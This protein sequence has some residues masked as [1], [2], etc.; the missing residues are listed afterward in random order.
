M[1]ATSS[2]PGDNRESDRA[3]SSHP[4][5][6]WV[7]SLGYPATLRGIWYPR[8]LGWPFLS[9]VPLTSLPLLRA[10]GT[11][12]GPLGND[13]ASGMR[14]HPLEL[15]P[16]T[17]PPASVSPACPRA[18]TAASFSYFHLL[19]ASRPFL[20][21]DVPPQSRCPSGPSP[22]F[23]FGHPGD[24]DGPTRSGPDGQWAE[25]CALLPPPTP[26]WS[27]FLLPHL[28]AGLT[29]SPR[30]PHRGPAPPPTPSLALQTQARS[31]SRRWGS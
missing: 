14:G 20:A 27:L 18:R 6:I 21:R 29:Q 26:S 4:S 2:C 16:P 7:P 31:R 8:S 3:G 30:P 19:P 17:G 15:P 11:S 25:S 10:P 23:G 28:P 22:V 1:A 12:R 5:G 13:M 9:L 24:A